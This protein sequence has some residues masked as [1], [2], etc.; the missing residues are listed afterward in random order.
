MSGGR[1]SFF[2]KSDY[3]FTN[4]AISISIFRCNTPSQR[5]TSPV[6][7]LTPIPPQ[8]EQVS[9]FFF[10]DVTQSYY[11]KYSHPE[12]H[13]AKEL[14]IYQ[15]GAGHRGMKKDG[16]KGCYLKNMASLLAKSRGNKGGNS[17][18]LYQRIGGHCPEVMVYG[19][20]G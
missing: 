17:C 3:F 2:G 10:I 4:F 5:H 11:E 15:T 19:L 18:A 14:S 12:Q 1:K 9:S 7:S 8:K 13:C 6:Y 20:P 16:G